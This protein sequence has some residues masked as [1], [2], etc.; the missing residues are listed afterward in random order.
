MLLQ[1][2]PLMDDSNP[3]PDNFL[4]EFYI[5]DYILLP[6]SEGEVLPHVPRCPV[7]VFINSKS[8]GQ[9]GGA[10]LITYRSLL[11]K[12]Q[13]FWPIVMLIIAEIWYSIELQHMCRPFLTCDWLLI[14]NIRFL[15]CWKRL[16]MMSYADCIS[17]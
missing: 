3:E 13:V 9:L 12:N 14:C 4:K 7:I 2:E 11:N 17:I 15:I 10:L 6:N 8:G 16:L 5:P 1:Y